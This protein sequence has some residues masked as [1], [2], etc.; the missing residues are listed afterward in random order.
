[1]KRRKRSIFTEIFLKIKL[2]VKEYAG[3]L[4]ASIGI[5]GLI[6]LYII[7]CCRTKVIP[8]LNEIDIYKIFNDKNVISVSE[9]EVYIFFIGLIVIILSPIL[10]FNDLRIGVGIS[11][12]LLLL[13]F[14][15]T[16][17]W[18]VIINRD[19][20]TL[21]IGWTTFTSIY[22]VFLSIYILKCLFRRKSTN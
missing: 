8:V 6:A 7:E 10:I 14:E 1:M 13:L 12:S 18:S 4:L 2:L 9:M 20:T 11:F 22:L 21:F 19:I 17:F 5:G 16:I 15:Y 3:M